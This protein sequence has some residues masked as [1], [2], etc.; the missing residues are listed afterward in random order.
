MA[1]RY[2]LQLEQVPYA[3]DPQFICGWHEG[4]PLLRRG[5]APRDLL[6]TF[7][8][9]REQGLRPGGRD[10]DAVLLT[11]HTPSGKA[12]FSSLW[13]ISK[14]VPVR[15]MT[16]AKRASIAKALEARRTCRECGEIGYIELPKAH[17]TCEACRVD[18]EA[19]DPCSCVHDYLVGIST[20]SAAEHAELDAQLST[21]RLAPVIPLQRDRSLV[22]ADALEAVTA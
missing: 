20:L 21:E 6:A 8:Q 14:C 17:R 9:L 22:A 3:R 2:A 10:P 16:A 5:C 13:L 12:N 1:R 7:R 18:V 19:L 11:K 15:P 4:L